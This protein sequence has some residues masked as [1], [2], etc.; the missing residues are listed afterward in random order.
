MQRE[1]EG[2]QSTYGSFVVRHDGSDGKEST[3][4]VG[5][6]GSIPGL[7]R[8][9]KEGN[10]YSFQYSGLENPHGQRSLVGYCPLGHRLGHN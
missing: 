6:L 2:V 10:S 8:F 7:G 9:P 3:C 4:H 5:G 1:S